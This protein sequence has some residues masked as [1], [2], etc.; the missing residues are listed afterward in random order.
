MTEPPKEKTDIEDKEDFIAKMRR[1]M[2]E[3][4]VEREAADKSRHDYSKDIKAMHDKVDVKVV[5]TGEMIDKLAELAGAEVENHIK[6]TSPKGSK[7]TG[8]LTAIAE[9]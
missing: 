8:A 5:K 3:V 1:E 6:R 4:R 7:T 9:E 2:E